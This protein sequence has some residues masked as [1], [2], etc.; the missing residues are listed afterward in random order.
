MLPSAP[1]GTGCLSQKV[2]KSQVNA[3]RLAEVQGEPRLA[4]K[5]PNE[6]QHRPQA[7]A[8]RAQRCWLESEPGRTQPCGQP[9]CPRNTYQRTEDH[10]SIQSLAGSVPEGPERAKS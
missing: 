5:S 9:D 6:R 10:K 7:S 2:K 1:T 4:A 3:D 8:E